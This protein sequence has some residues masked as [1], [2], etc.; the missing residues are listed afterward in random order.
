[1][2]G[3]NFSQVSRRIRKEYYDRWMRDPLRIDPQTKMPRYSADGRSTQVREILD[4]QAPRQ[5]EALWQY[6]NT[7]RQ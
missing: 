1:V 4:G 6:L 7:V 3:I 2:L 5:F